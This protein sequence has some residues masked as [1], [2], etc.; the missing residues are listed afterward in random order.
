MLY[1]LPA[2][3]AANITASNGPGPKRIPSPESPPTTEWPFRRANPLHFWVRSR[4]QRSVN[5]QSQL[6]WPDSRRR[7]PIRIAGR[8]RSAPLRQPISASDASDAALPRG[9]CPGFVPESWTGASGHE[10]VDRIVELCRNP[11]GP[12]VAELPMV[13]PADVGPGICQASTS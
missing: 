9:V 13:M 10:A 6:P 12:R 1:P 7:H 8:R 11:N 2:Q 4:Y 3:I 5:P